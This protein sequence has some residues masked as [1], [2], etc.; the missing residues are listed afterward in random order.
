M[1]FQ[2]KEFVLNILFPPICAN[3]RKRIIAEKNN[4]FVCDDCLAL[5]QIN[6]T[7]FCPIC[8]AR[9]PENKRICGHKNEKFKEFPYLLGA[10]SDFNNETLQ[11]LIYNFKYQH[12]KWLAPALGNIMV[13]YL[14]TMN[15]KLNDFII[16]PIPLHKSRE[17]F[18]GY[19]QSELLA[20]FV[21]KEFNLEVNPVLKRI[22]KTCPQAQEK[23]YENRKKN[24][25]GAFKISD[26]KSAADK[27]IILIDDVYTSGAT[28]SEAAR[29]LKEGGAKNI[30]AL[31]LAKA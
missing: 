28:I 14:K 22:K 23:K 6:N 18:R 1:V 24:T 15:L 8:Q 19:N 2:L 31:V 21:G 9:L 20:E 13:S 16:I 26:F 17:R 10:V 27:N 29:T 25:A 5:I 4:K 30:I 11:N 3:C 12:L 7:L